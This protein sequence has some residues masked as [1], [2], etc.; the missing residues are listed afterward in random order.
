MDV[1]AEV[2]FDGFG[3]GFGYGFVVEGVRMGGGLERT[4]ETLKKILLSVE[5][6]PF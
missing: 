6:I 3:V 1:V 2:G 5:K 4:R